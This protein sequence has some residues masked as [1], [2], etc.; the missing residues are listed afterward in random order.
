VQINKEV[1]IWEHNE[2]K[3]YGVI[4]RVA[5]V[6]NNSAKVTSKGW[7]TTLKDRKYY[8]SGTYTK[9]WSAT[10]TNNV[11]TDVLGAQS[12]LSSGTLYNNGTNFNFKNEN[13]TLYDSVKKLVK[14]G[15]G[16]FEVVKT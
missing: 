15:L 14:W 16:D 3:H 8:N 12:T 4:R 2:L 9:T 10:R 1:E 5:Y 6:D 13:E 7:I 11:M